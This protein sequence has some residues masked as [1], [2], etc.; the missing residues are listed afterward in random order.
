MKALVH[1]DLL[2]WIF[3]PST[4]VKSSIFAAALIEFKVILDQ[5]GKI[6]SFETLIGDIEKNYQDMLERDDMPDDIRQ[7]IKSIVD[8]IENIKRRD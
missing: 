6:Y 8:Q 2:D 5:R 1:D 4:L 7:N 3:T